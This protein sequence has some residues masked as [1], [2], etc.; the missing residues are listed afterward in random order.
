MKE[1]RPYVLVSATFLLISLLLSVL[2]RFSLMNT[3]QAGISLILVFGPYLVYGWR[4][5]T[6]LCDKSTLL[7]TTI[8]V[9]IIIFILGSLLVVFMAM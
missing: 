7:C 3:W 9:I 6:K 5:S 8:R 1:L 4:K 2:F